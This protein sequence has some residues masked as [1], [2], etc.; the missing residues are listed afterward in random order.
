MTRDL[1]SLV[2]LARRTARSRRGGRRAR[3]GMNLI[4]VML[5]IAILLSLLVIVVPMV[6]WA[7]KLG[8]KESATDLVA[9]YERLRD[10]AVLRNLT[11]RVAYHLED[12]YYEV[13]VSED[14]ALLF[15]DPETRERF[16]AAQQEKMERSASRFADTD[17]NAM[18]G[19]DGLSV[20]TASFT[21]VQDKFLKRF[22]L[23]SGVVFGGVYTPA[24]GELVEPLRDDP[25]DLEEHEKTVIYSYIL[26][27]GIAE[28]TFVTLVQEGDP[29]RGYTIEVEPMTGVVHVDREVRDWRDRFDFVPEEGPKL[30][31]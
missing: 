17:S 23:P 21:K 28:H 26:P 15:A 14:A 18:I 8:H 10:E 16:E 24:Y 7:L 6:G 11:F 31:Q 9:V 3:R 4:E 13:E 2:T 30:A 12:R 1:A 25:E 19:E 29:D 20:E 5:V 27:S 22:D